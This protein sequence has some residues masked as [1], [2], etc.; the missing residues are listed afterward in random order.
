MT[1]I[2]SESRKLAMTIDVEDYFQVSAFEKQI[3]PSDWD[4]Y[5]CRVEANVQ[6][7]LEMLAAQ[8]DTKATFFI[9]G[10]IAER[11][12]ALVKEIHALGH[13][14]ASHGYNHQRLTQMPRERF[15]DDIQRSKSLLEELTG[16]QV[17]GYRAPSFSLAAS[18]L[19]AVDE[20]LEA[21]Y[22]YSSSV[23][24][25]PH[26]LYGFDNAPRTPFV[27]HNGL[28]ELPVATLS[29][30]DRRWPCA[31]G[32]FFRLYPYA[33]TR[34]ALH[35]S[36]RQLTDAPIIFYLHPW[37]LDPQQ[38]RIEHIS[39]KSRFR[40]YLNLKHTEARLGRLL[41]DFNWTRIDRLGGYTSQTWTAESAA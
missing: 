19:W 13:E 14:V 17:K 29:M 11:Y 28:Q 40:H 4:A 35:Q 21:G 9:L 26:D 22:Q 38:P 27:W 41:Q 12:P 10:W 18:C 20:L 3:D 15:R 23:N 39:A 5:E 33:L 34:W 7:I 25:V 6:R 24:P 2:D 30:M 31:G 8:G 36:A 32:G 37:E 16:E 1:A